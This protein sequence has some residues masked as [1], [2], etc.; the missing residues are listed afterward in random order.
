MGRQIVHHHDVALAQGRREKLLD[1]GQK[2]RPVH[3]SVEDT[4]R[5]DL[6]AT[7]GADE[8]GR[9]PVA[10]RRS[11]LEA[12]PARGPA[13]KPNHIRLGA[14]FVNEDKLFWVQ[15]GLAFAPVLTRLSDIG[16]I[17]LGGAQ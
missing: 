7:Q 13:I 10:K 14:G 2:A 15:I 4:R 1:I 16:T 3:R 8:S 17:L 9:H 5:G 6:I 12:A 11:R